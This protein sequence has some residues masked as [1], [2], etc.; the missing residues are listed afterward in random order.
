MQLIH[1]LR[2]F[3]T[4]FEP[5]KAQQ[6]ALGDTFGGSCIACIAA[7]AQLLLAW[8]PQVRHCSCCR[9]CGRTVLQLQLATGRS[10]PD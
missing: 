8:Q 1:R 2:L 6:A 10:A 3:P 7:A 5:P 4:V 9:I